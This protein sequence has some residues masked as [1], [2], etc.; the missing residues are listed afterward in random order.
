MIKTTQEWKAR[1][2][3]RTGFHKALH[4][5]YY[6]DSFRRRAGEKFGD[7]VLRHG[8][9]RHLS[10]VHQRKAQR[11]KRWMPIYPSKQNKH[12]A[13]YLATKLAHKYFER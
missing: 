10:E 1:A 2:N 7:F 8:R 6:Y 9:Q 5:H 13:H 11:V 4:S 3:W 12:K